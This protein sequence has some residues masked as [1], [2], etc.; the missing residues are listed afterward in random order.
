MVLTLN[1]VWLICC[2]HWS[3]CLRTGIHME[4]LVLADENKQ[5]L[6]FALQM[7]TRVNSDRFNITGNVC[8]DVISDTLLCCM[9]DSIPGLSYYMSWSPAATSFGKDTVKTPPTSFHSFTDVCLPGSGDNL[10]SCFICQCLW[11]NMNVSSSAASESLLQDSSG[12]QGAV[13]YLVW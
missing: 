1:A 7:A 12:R 2:S 3:V 5:V 10:L 8:C 6:E 9:H 13:C 11:L 4:L